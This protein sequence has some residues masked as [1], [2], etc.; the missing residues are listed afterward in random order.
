[1]KRSGKKSFWF[2]HT[3]QVLAMHTLKVYARSSPYVISCCA[4]LVAWSIVDWFSLAV[5]CVGLTV[6]D[7]NWGARLISFNIKAWQCMFRHRVRITSMLQCQV[8]QLASLKLC[9]EVCLVFN[10][11][12]YCSTSEATAYSWDDLV[13]H[14]TKAS[15]RTTKKRNAYKEKTC[16]LWQT[17]YVCSSVAMNLP[18]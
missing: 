9:W 7:L 11:A 10:T 17:K 16:K 2:N 4:H 14:S 5:Y 1:M 6:E 18:T 13:Q 12:M 8:H 15:R 3:E